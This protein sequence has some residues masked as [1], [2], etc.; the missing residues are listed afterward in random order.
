MV[1]RQGLCEWLCS[2]CTAQR[3]LAKEMSEMG[4]EIHPHIPLSKPFTLVGACICLKERTA[5][6]HLSAQRGTFS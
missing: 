4:P 2:L 3:G 1:S 6:S 5:F